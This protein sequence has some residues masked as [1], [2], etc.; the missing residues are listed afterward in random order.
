MYA[1]LVTSLS[2]LR[3]SDGKIYSDWDRR[4]M[5]I[6]IKRSEIPVIILLLAHNVLSIVFSVILLTVLVTAFLLVVRPYVHREGLGSVELDLRTAAAAD[7]VDTATVSPLSVGLS[8]FY[9]L[10]QFLLKWCW[11]SLGVPMG[12]ASTTKT[13][14]YYQLAANSEQPVNYAQQAIICEGL[15]STMARAIGFIE[16]RA[17]GIDTEWLN[18]WLSAPQHF[19]RSKGWRPCGVTT[20][21]ASLLWIPHIDRYCF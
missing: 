20:A 17:K 5:Q 16:T 21:L 3:H 6:R 8:L 19:I 15:Q 1:F 4:F 2:R 13:S 7:S 14:N 12:P 9:I 11:F 18:Y 10:K